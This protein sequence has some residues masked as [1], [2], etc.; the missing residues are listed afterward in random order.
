[1]EHVEVE[2]AAVVAVANPQVD[3]RSRSG[4]AKC[5]CFTS[6]KAEK[7]ELTEAMD[8]ICCQQ[9]TSPETGRLHW[10]G[11]VEMRERQQLSFMKTQIDNETHFEIRRGTQ[12][13]AIEYTQKAESAVQGTWFEVGVKHSPDARGMLD[14]CINDLKT[15]QFTLTQ[16]AMTHLKVMVLHGRGVASVA[17]L[18]RPPPPAWRVMDVRVYYGAPGS[19]KTSC[20]IREFPDIYIQ[21]GTEWFQDYI[22]QK[23]LLLDDFYGGTRIATILRWLDGHPLRLPVKGTQAYAYWTV[24]IL[25]SNH[26]PDRWWEKAL[27]ADCETRRALMRRINTIVHL[28]D[29]G[30]KQY[31]KGGPNEVVAAAPVAAVVPQPNAE[32]EAQ[33]LRRRFNAQIAQQ[34]EDD[35][36]QI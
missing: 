3:K 8:Y 26:H 34:E 27:S 32:A 35:W 12:E 2:G 14:A 29:D 6:F 25:T 18:I 5:W 20:A 10:Q 13:K 19:G 31:D 4:G 30:T 36:E 24:V 23:Q 17:C 15:G 16:L 7:P 28:S 33:A 21:D 1:M 9:E 11:Y 22:D